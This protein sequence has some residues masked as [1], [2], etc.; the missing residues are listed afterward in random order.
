MINIFKIM[1]TGLVAGALSFSLPAAAAVEITI[2]QDGLN[3]FVTSV[4]SINLTGLSLITSVNYSSAPAIRATDAF[5]ATGINALTN[6][7]SGITG[8][9][10][11]GSGAVINATSGTGDPFGLNIF[12]VNTPAGVAR[13]FLPLNYQS[14]Q[15]INSTATFANTTISSLGLTVGSY[16]FNAPNDSIFINI[17]GPAVPEP[18]T[19]AMMVIG[20][21]FVG[22]AMRSAKRRQTP[23]VSY[24]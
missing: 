20:L 19:W 23:A 12:P 7:Y 4:G 5:V 1:R 8:I 10:N 2:K 14:G 11:I 17:I 24:G 3:V 6:G 18:A 21:G 22:G 13:I 16:T 9:R 15:A